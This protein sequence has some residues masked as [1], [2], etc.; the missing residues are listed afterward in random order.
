MQE[1]T[2]ESFEQLDSLLT[3][4]H[5]EWWKWYYRGVSRASYKLV[6]KAGRPPFAVKNDEIIFDKWK[7]HA[8]AYL[9]SGPREL[10][11]CDM[12]AIAQHHGLAT[13]LLDWSF[14]PMTA[15]FFATVDADGTIDERSDGAIYAHYSTVG[16]LETPS[17]DELFKIPEI[18][19][20][21]PSSVTPRIGQQGGIFTSHNPPTTSLEDKLPTGDRVIKLIIDRKFKKPFSIKLSHYGVNRMSLFPDLDG[22]SAHINWSF[23]ALPF[24]S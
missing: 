11:N 3:P 1:H 9:P 8:F 12:L 24:S 21:A 14:N 10:S 22:L 5:E 23:H 6:P 4:L 20:L 13:R 19:R 2:I 7:R 17:G 16:I 18:R 15:A